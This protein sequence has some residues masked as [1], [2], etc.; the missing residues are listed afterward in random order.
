MG[1]QEIEGI[2]SRTDFDLKR[3]QEFSG[4]KMEYFDPHRKEKYIPYV[5]E[6]SAGLD[7]TILMLLCEA[8]EEERV[9]GEERI[10]MKFH[11][12]VAP[13]KA[14]VFPLVKR[15]GMPETAQALAADLRGHFNAFYDDSGS[16]G[17]RYRR[18]DEAGTPFCIT[19]DGETMETGAVTVRDRD[20]MIQERIPK[21]N[22]ADYLKDRMRAWS[23]SV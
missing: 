21:D 16:I 3:H 17:K 4:K 8:Y 19:V 22:A 11:P 23:R 20:S 13:I 2:H 15:D 1:W 5:V 14:A 18:M 9:E 6:T 7:R 12:E 10:V